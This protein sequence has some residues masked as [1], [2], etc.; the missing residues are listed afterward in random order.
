MNTVYREFFAPEVP[1]QNTVAVAEF[2]E[3]ADVQINAVDVRR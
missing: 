2:L 3:D 1:A